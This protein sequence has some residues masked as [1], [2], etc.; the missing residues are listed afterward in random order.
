MKSLEC[1]SISAFSVCGL[2][3]ATEPSLHCFGRKKHSCKMKSTKVQTLSEVALHATTA[4]TDD[5][6]HCWFK[7]MHSTGL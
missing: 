4:C 6:K 7:F 5:A 1:V 2:S 3:F